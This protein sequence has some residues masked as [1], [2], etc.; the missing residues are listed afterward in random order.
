MDNSLHKT[1]LQLVSCAVTNQRLYDMGEPTIADAVYDQLIAQIQAIELRNPSW[2][3]EDSPTHNVVAFAS[4][5]TK[6]KQPHA[7]RMLSLD[8]IS[9]VDG[10]TQFLNRTNRST[11]SV[12]PKYDGMSLELVYSFGRLIRALTRGNGWVGDDFYDNAIKVQGIPLKIPVTNNILAPHGEIVLP[13]EAFARINTIRIERGVKP[14]ANPRGAAVGILTGDGEFAHELHFVLWDIPL[15]PGENSNNFF[16]GLNHCKRLQ[17]GH[18]LKIGMVKPQPSVDY[19]NVA[20]RIEEITRLRESSPYLLDGVVIKLD[21]LLE[22]SMYRVVGKAPRWATAWK[23]APKGEVTSVRDIIFELSALGALTPVAIID[24]IMVDGVSIRRVGLHNQ[25]VLRSLNLWIGDR[26][27]VIR[28]FDVNNVIN[29]VLFDERPKDATPAVVPDN[30][31]SCQQPLSADN[32]WQE[33]KRCNHYFTCPDQL[34]LRVKRYLGPSGIGATL[35]MPLVKLLIRD[36][37][38]T[39]L[40]D[41]YDLQAIDLAKYQIAQGRASHYVNLIQSGLTFARRNIHLS[42]MG[43]PGVSITTADKLLSVMDIARIPEVALSTNGRE[44]LGLIIG[45]ATA[46]KLIDFCMDPRGSEVLV[47]IGRLL[48]D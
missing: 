38:I 45:L 33:T 27:R 26:V 32:K 12:E 11:Y 16:D 19:V 40:A 29:E 25:E 28:A 37:H 8:N 48:Q 7:V 35:P 17:W 15:L 46:E 21:D 34:A 10:L 3:A 1:Y 42:A 41:L 6:G 9:E 14:Y 4:Y 44:N 23:F 18:N 20:E 30:C 39:S 47:R 2:I 22:R 36:G 5:D 13:L 43:I 24:P 31:P